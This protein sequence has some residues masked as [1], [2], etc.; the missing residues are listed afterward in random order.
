M[1]GLCYQCQ[2]WRKR[3]K[4]FSK[5][6]V[7]MLLCLCTLCNVFQ[8]FQW[9]VTIVL[10]F[11]QGSSCQSFSLVFLFHLSS[12]LPCIPSTIQLLFPCPIAHPH[13]LL[14]CSRLF[15]GSRSNSLGARVSEVG[16]PFTLHSSRILTFVCG[17]CQIVI[18]LPLEVAGLQWHEYRY[19][20]RDPGQRRVSYLPLTPTTQY[21]FYF[22][23]LSSA[24]SATIFV[25]SCHHFLYQ[26]PSQNSPQTW[27]VL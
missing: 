9:W 27:E 16:F 8:F 13:L 26:L 25:L 6:Q 22:L 17:K 14:Y 4:K 1:N 19:S 20:R 2:E 5:I 11:G 10:Y 24:S 7:L 12:Q 3:S 18:S 21:C 23:I 15:G